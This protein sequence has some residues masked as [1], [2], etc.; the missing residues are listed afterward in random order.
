MRVIVVILLFFGVFMI[1]FG[2]SAI[3][4]CGDQR[5]TCRF[6]KEC[7]N[8]NKPIND[9]ISNGIRDNN[10]QLVWDGLNAC[11]TFGGRD[12]TIDGRKFSDFA[13]GCD[14]YAQ[15]ARGISNCN[16]FPE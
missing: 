16:Q 14:N 9:S 7:I 10:N 6:I 11:A 4:R 13:A 2:A 3:A 8:A 15:L 1:D 5:M 12:N